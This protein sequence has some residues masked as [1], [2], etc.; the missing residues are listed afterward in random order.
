MHPLQRYA[1]PRRETRLIRR[2][3][4]PSG[5]VDRDGPTPV[6]PTSSV[7]TRA[8]RD[9]GS[10]ATSWLTAA[11]PPG[12]F[13]ST[14]PA[15]AVEHRDRTLVPRTGAPP[16]RPAERRPADLGAPPSRPGPRRPPTPL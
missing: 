1:R 11:R 8:P 6:G 13:Q 5:P 14:P 12:R 15:P 3:R 7:A 2:T 16:A 4:R 9:R 10:H